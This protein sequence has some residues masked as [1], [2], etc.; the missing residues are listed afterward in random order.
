M[1]SK[2]SAVIITLNEERDLPGCLDSLEGLADEVVVVD[3]GSRDGTLH[4][5]R[6]RGAKVFERAFDGYGPQKQ[7]AVERAAGEWVLSLDADER[8]TPELA[9]E[10]RGLLAGRPPREDAF[11]VPFQIFFMGRRL[12]FGGCFRESHIRL[13]RRGRARFEPDM[14]HEGLL[15]EGAVGALKAAVRH[16]SYR[17]FGEHLEK[18]RR[19]TAAIAQRKFAQGKRF[20]PWQHLRLPWEFFVRYVAKLGFLDGSAGFAYAALSAYYAWLKHA[21]LVDWERGTSDE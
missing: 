19:Y 8:A 7:F 10:I 1:T 11:R 12:R 21:R 17:N 5:A 2:L 20:Q 15:V 18:C 3:S 13:F 4:I 16:E 14:V 6:R 9:A